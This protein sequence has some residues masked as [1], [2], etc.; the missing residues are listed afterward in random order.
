MPGNHR[1]QVLLL[2]LFL[3]F[4]DFK[5]ALAQPV[6]RI[7]P[8]HGFR[9]SRVE[10]QYMAEI[11]KNHYF[12]DFGKDAFGTL[13]L[14]FRTGHPD[15]LIIHLGEKSTTDNRV[16][17]QPGGTIRYQKV[18]L[19]LDPTKKNYEIQLPPDKRN[20]GPNAVALP[21]TMGVIMPFRY[22]EIENMKIPLTNWSVSQKA[23][24]FRFKDEASEFISSDQVLN[25]VWDLCKY[26]IKATS[27]SGLYIDG[28]RERIPY[29]ADALINQLSHYAVD[30]EYAMA[31]QTNEYFITHP[32]WPTEWILHTV[33]L[34][35]N[36][37]LYTADKGPITKHYEAL[38]NKTLISLERE[39]GLISTKTG[40]LTDE[41]IGNLGF[42]DK[43]QRIRDIVD[44]P[45]GERDGYQMVDINTVVN[46]FYYRNLVLMSQ[47]AGYLGKQNDSTLYSQKSLLVKLAFNNKLLDKEKGIYLD[48]EG[49]QHSSLHANLFPL[50]FG[51]VPD[52]FKQSV[53]SLIK[54]K[55]MACSVYA[56]QYLLEGLYTAG[57]SP[58]ALYLLTSTGERSWW[59]MIRSGST[60]AMEAWDMKFKPNSDWNHAWGAAPANI[61]TRCLW[62]ITPA[63]PGFARAAIR[64]QLG[65]LTY[66]KIKVPT[67][68]GG[69]ECEYQWKNNSKEFYII[70]LP[71]NMKADFYLVPSANSQVV[72]NGKETEP[73]TSQISLITGINRIEITK[74]VNNH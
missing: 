26:T 6:Q 59:N 53:I 73:E 67:N 39:D 50:A 30:N 21:D 61:I 11:A 44:W 5:L 55:E 23:Y 22:C 41:I 65:N 46:A 10:P 43:N 34:F 27:F 31:R 60:I 28:D 56:A 51:L 62:G 4:T 42:S 33:L 35:Y 58:Y 69:I 72:V 54:S 45:E 32:T 38:K 52:E 16:D 74:S 66:S 15:T 20:T 14:K 68:R 19:I 7:P 40:K 49:S 18:F 17:R 57:E 25:Q 1:H 8:D 3:L 48:G 47:I 36:D 12:F 70:R 63:E 13:V 37:Y 24:H 2:L 64:P 71:K 29:E 9:A